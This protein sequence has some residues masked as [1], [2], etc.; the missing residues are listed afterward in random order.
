MRLP[1]ED[2][3]LLALSPDGRTIAAT[4]DNKIRIFTL[5]DGK[6]SPAIKAPSKNLR[7]IAFALDGK[8]LA[9]GDD[10]GRVCLF[11][12]PE[13]NVTP[14]ELPEQK[15]EKMWQSLQSQEAEAAFRA[16]LVLLD[17]AAATLPFL[18]TR[19]AEELKTSDE[20]EIDKLIAQLDDD[21]FKKREQAGDRIRQLGALAEPHL[22]KAMSK[23]MPSLELR[24]RVEKLL[25][26]LDQALTSRST[27]SF[28]RAIEVLEMIGTDEARTLLAELAKKGED[29][30]WAL[31]VERA[32]DRIDL[33]NLARKNFARE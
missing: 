7:A 27:R 17:S 24:R 28:A 2:F 30:G 5:A 13:V 12:L 10:D 21:D 8:H 6:E 18:K 16:Q 22:K 14:A 26:G 9:V 29:A 33:R 15:L 11:A 19:L 1:K 31:D 4:Q 25:E 20:T 3:G 23:E 32:V